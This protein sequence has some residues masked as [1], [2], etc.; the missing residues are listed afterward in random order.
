MTIIWVFLAILL[1][2]IAL[3]F[4]SGEKKVTHRV[5]H[6]Y[7]I[8]DRNFELTISNLLGPSLLEGNKLTTLIN[9][10]QIFSAML[11]AIAEAKESICF[12][13]FIYWQGSIGKKFTKLLCKKAKE[14]VSVHLILDAIGTGK[15]DKVSLKEMVDSGVEVERYHPLRFYNLSRLN[16]RTHRKLLI[17]DGKIGFTG[18]VGIADQWSGNA[19]NAHEWRDS[20]FKLEGPTVLQ[21]QGAF[22]DN[23]LKT[24]SKVLHGERY[25]K[26]LQKVGEI[27][28]QVFTSS[29]DEGS[30]SVRVMYLISL[31]A[32]SETILIANA[33]FIPD[34]LTVQTLVEAAQRGVN[35]E[36]IVPGR[37]IDP[38]IVRQAS[39]ARWGKLLEAG[40]KIFEYE[41][42]MFH[43]KVMIVD[44]A[45]VSVGSTN[46]DSRS[47]RLND[48]ANLNI[49]DETF[50]MEQTK[51]FAEDRAKSKMITLDEW[52]RR[53]IMEKITN[54]LVSTLRS[55]L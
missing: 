47:F 10:D 9:G 12:E 49:Y 46:F 8:K 41:P 16:Y 7:G 26:A 25:F 4:T 32:A 13:T 43:C 29:A 44:G 34:N 55:Q 3:N 18:G 22:L 30:D 31:A 50:A 20:H 54:F 21:M 28:S 24:K 42:T 6:L 2:I 53:P 48:E 51:I 11:A 5:E 17:V 39:R 19:R 37:Q 23:W 52:Q 14:G 27:R 38:K 45:F 35:I 33:Y 1:V 15:L 36:V 40:I